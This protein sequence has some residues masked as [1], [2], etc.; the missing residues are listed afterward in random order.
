MSS[1]FRPHGKFATRVDGRLIISEV[2]GPW[3][4]ELVQYWGQRCLPE[5]TLVAAGGPWVGIAII[6]ESMLCPPDA[7]AVLRR[8]AAHSASALQCAAHVIVA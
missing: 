1:A 5:A 8:I 2:T 6:H 3:N 7:L 4:K